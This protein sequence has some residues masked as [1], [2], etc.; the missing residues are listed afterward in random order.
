M[1]PDGR[2]SYE[3]IY[4]T[5]IFDVT[6]GMSKVEVPNWWVLEGD[7]LAVWTEGNCLGAYALT[8]GNTGQVEIAQGQAIQDVVASRGRLAT[9]ALA[10]QTTD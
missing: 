5:E 1:R 2:G 9:Q 3:T 7:R 8:S 10:I 4:R 6:P